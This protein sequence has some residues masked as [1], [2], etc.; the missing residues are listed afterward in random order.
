ME[1][2]SP[3]SRQEKEA[4]AT[5]R[6]LSII[7]PNL[8]LKGFTKSADVLAQ[9]KTYSSIYEYCR[10]ENFT[11]E[12]KREASSFFEPVYRIAMIAGSSI[13]GTTTGVILPKGD[14]FMRGSPFPSE[15]SRKTEPNTDLFPAMSLLYDLL[16]LQDA[17]SN[18]SFVENYPYRGRD[19]IEL[20]GET[21]VVPEEWQDYHTVEVS[22]NSG[23]PE[24][25]LWETWK[26]T[27]GSPHPETNAYV[28]PVRTSFGL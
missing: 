26:Y 16:D 10:A 14:G 22:F 23:L 8:R 20:E 12:E 19:T 13:V 21:I 15:L 2:P 3:V 27:P 18:G 17:R 1:V 7:V 25:D 4:Q 6:L 9:N 24:V 5:H 28:G 11:D